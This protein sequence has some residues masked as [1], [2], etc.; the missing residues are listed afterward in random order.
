M[1]EDSIHLY[2]EQLASNEPV[3]GGGSAAALVGALG[4]ALLEKACNLTVG[5]E[6]FK[7]VEKDI[8]GILK[9][10]TAAR[11]RLNELIDLD[12]KVYLA[13]AEACKLPKDTE[14]QKAARKQ[15]IQKATDE[16]RK[17]PQEV[18]VL[19]DGL[20][21]HCAELEIKGN[22]LLA[23]DVRCAKEL[24]TAASR[25]AINFT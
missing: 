21:S 20:I 25:A 1:C 22:P 6:R 11:H 4:A 14:Q 15:A 19:C 10:A 24:L 2:L 18:R 17:V 16:A 8:L 9:K 7:A 12:K 3:P 5:K 23:G 13:V